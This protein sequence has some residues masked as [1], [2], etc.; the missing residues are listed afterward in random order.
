M[1]FTPSFASKKIAQLTKVIY[2]LHTQNDD[3]QYEVAAI[4]KDHEGEL[5]SGHGPELLLVTLGRDEVH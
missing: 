1:S 4:R 3:H 2:H 5:A